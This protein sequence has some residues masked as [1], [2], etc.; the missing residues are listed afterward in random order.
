MHMLSGVLYVDVQVLCLTTTLR[1][2][3]ADCCLLQAQR[4][5]DM[6]TIAATSCLA[7]TDS[8]TAAADI[9]TD[10]VQLLQTWVA[11]GIDLINHTQAGTILQEHLNGLAIVCL[12][13][14]TDSRFCVQPFLAQAGC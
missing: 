7:P 12:V 1:R 13:G 6:V 11:V 2:A 8:C 4:N 5:F 9:N 3:V 10:S 14:G